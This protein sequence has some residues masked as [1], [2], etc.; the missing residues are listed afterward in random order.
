[1]L[2]QTCHSKTTQLPQFHTPGAIPR[3]HA[4]AG[5]ANDPARPSRP[6]IP[7]VPKSVKRGW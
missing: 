6:L 7:F 3:Q 5:E 1:L 2:P 4:G